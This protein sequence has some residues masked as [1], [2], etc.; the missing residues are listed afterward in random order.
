M[1]GLFKSLLALPHRT[2]RLTVRTLSGATDR[3]HIDF[4]PI[5]GLQNETQALILFSLRENATSS[6]VSWSG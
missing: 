3:R 4:L 2:F 5:A 6:E 1:I